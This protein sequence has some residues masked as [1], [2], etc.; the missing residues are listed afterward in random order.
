MVAMTEMAAAM[1]MAEMLA[2]EMAAAE[3]IETACQRGCWPVSSVSDTRII[4]NITLGIHP[5]PPLQ[6][7]LCSHE[8]LY[9][10][11]LVLQ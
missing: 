10:G 4:W 11:C 8:G 2:A 9:P 1:A 5:A 6:S 3:T 7:Y